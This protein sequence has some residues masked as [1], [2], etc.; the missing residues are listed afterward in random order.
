MSKSFIE[1]DCTVSFEGKAFTAGGASIVGDRIVAYI[2]KVSEAQGPEYR[3]QGNRDLTDWHGNVIGRC[4]LAKSWATPRSYVSS[5]MYQV[6]ATVDG[7]TYTGRSAGEGMSF[8][9]KRT[10]KQAKV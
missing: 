1:T 5:R 4:R 8:S 2:G 9:G 10:A 6:Y 7:V 3:L